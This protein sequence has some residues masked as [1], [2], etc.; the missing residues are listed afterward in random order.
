MKYGKKSSGFKP[1]PSCKTKS[2]CRAAGMCKKMSAK[3]KM[4]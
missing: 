3:I 2:A 4:A 1:C